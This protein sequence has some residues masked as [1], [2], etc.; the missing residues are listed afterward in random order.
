M[1]ASP[2]TIEAFTLGP[3]ETNCYLLSSFAAKEALAIDPGGDP[4]QV[5]A[6]LAASQRKLSFIL[7]THA[8]PDHTGGNL[9]LKQKTGASLLI[10]RAE[11]G[12]LPPGNTADRLLEEGDQ[13]VLGKGALALTVLHTP[14]HT[15]GSICLLGDGCILVGD[16]L[17]A[18][19]VGRT[20]L[21]GG[22]ERDLLRSLRRLAA[23]DPGLRVYPGHGPPT[24]IG[25][26]L[27]T[28]PWLQNL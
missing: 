17:F 22:S 3:L 27:K 15:P 14:G 20:D 13:I 25:Q 10:H 23:L 16:C 26:E 7:N 1:S 5:L 2:P 19:G 8:H 28:N 21:P 11:A 12:A 24:T 6:A 18:G 9:L 4:R